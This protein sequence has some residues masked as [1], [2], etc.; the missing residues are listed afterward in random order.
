MPPS[1]PLTHTGLPMHKHMLASN[2]KSSFVCTASYCSSKDVFGLKKCV[3]QISFIFLSC[4]ER[5]GG[6]VSCSE[7]GV[8]VL[9]LA[10]LIPSTWRFETRQHTKLIQKPQLRVRLPVNSFCSRPFPLLLG[11]K[12]TL[13]QP[14]SQLD[15]KLGM[16]ERQKW[17][18]LLLRQ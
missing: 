1:L 17:R 12:M 6:S 15:S 2:S 5:V 3:P 13:L 18:I 16:K 9:Q 7:T 8:T 14:D 10:Q 11:F 4:L